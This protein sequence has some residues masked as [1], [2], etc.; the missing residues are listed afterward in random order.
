[1]RLDASGLSTV[2]LAAIIALASFAGLFAGPAG[3]QDT[4]AADCT[5]WI[6]QSD[7]GECNA[8]QWRWRRQCERG[9]V[10]VEQYACS[11]AHYTPGLCLNNSSFLPGSVDSC[12]GS[13]GEWVWSADVE[14][15]GGDGWARQCVSANGT[16]TVWEQSCG[17]LQPGSCDAAAS[18]I[19]E[20]LSDWAFQPY[21]PVATYCGKVSCSHD[22][23]YY[24][25]GTA[26]WQ[27]IGGDGL[28]PGDGD[29][30][31]FD[32]TYP[33][34]G[35]VSFPTGTMEVKSINYFPGEHYQGRMWRNW[36]YR[37][38]VEDLDILHD[39][40][41]NTLR[42][43]LHESD[44][45]SDFLADS[46]AKV[47]RFLCEARARGMR[48]VFTLLPAHGPYPCSEDLPEHSRTFIEN[49]VIT[50]SQ[51]PNVL[52]WELANEPFC[53][54]GGWND[55]PAD[56]QTRLAEDLTSISS[57]TDQD[58]SVPVLQDQ[59][60][61]LQPDLLAA[62]DVLNFHF[63]DHD[64]E[65]DAPTFR[66]YFDTAVAVAGDRPIFIGEFGC[67]AAPF[68]ETNGQAPR[69][70][71]DRGEGTR[72]E[73]EEDQ[74]E[75]IQSVFDTAVE[76][77]VTGIAPWMFSETAIFEPG[78]GEQNS[79]YALFPSFGLVDLDNTLK[80]S[81]QRLRDLY[82]DCP[83]LTEKGGIATK[84]VCQVQLPLD[85]VLLVDTTGSMWDDIAQVKSE[86]AEIVDAI[87]GITPD[88]RVAV[89]DFRDFSVSPY[90]GSEDYPYVLRGDFSTSQS[91]ILSAITSL[92]LGWGND[93]PESVYSGLMGV[94]Q[95]LPDEVGARLAPWRAFA[96]KIIIVMG[97]A[98]PHD[99][100]PFTGY[101]LQDVVDTA[102]SGGS[103]SF[104]K[105]G[106][107]I[108]IF[109]VVIGGSASAQYYYQG[110]AEGTAGALLTAA[111]ADEV[112]DA[113]LEALGGVGGPPSNQPPAVAGAYPSLGQLWPP[114]HKMTAVEV[115]GITDPDGDPFTVEVTGV[116]QDEAV[117]G[118][119]KNHPD[120]VIDAGTVELRAERDG[121]GNG[122]RVYEVSFTAT[123]A[124]GASASGSVFVCV[125]HDQGENH[126]CVDD[127]QIYDST[128]P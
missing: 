26:G 102:L 60:D 42:V 89:A 107:P 124:G 105:A 70:Y 38:I 5:S 29:L 71:C 58:V 106:Y 96:E 116:T 95:G 28:C 78:T 122:G 111:D 126:P 22:G 68:D 67:L 73:L 65:I 99:P 117:H 44:L 74:A 75:W 31:A 24:D 114:N 83:G 40:N 23:L 1:M 97:D 93:F 55:I 110:L 127:G 100:E 90:G 34:T 4:C 39:M 41:V 20:G 84:Q 47:D 108:R 2:T 48:V 37:R 120:A 17:S 25:C 92:D 69:R 33:R 3:A 119:G 32:C 43:F 16:R 87:A 76:F 103:S 66:A 54:E 82:G 121:N 30:P 49:V 52:L 77:E 21:D 10:T 94:I 98:P 91:A 8:A 72:A 19:C 113:I 35:P 88:Y 59:I 115:L 14:A 45:G 6:F 81:G 13:C 56:V 15:C 86:A 109:S 7:R 9:K 80:P 12:T 46:E 50:Y 104:Y 53:G 11:P 112:V 36:D 61:N 27:D 51:D 85:V 123:D 63:Y 118:P 125:P 79:E 128:T 64:P 62:T 57:L 18:C 101:T